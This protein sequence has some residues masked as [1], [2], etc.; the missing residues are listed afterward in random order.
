MKNI[1]NYIRNSPVHTD[2]RRA[3]WH[4]RHRKAKRANMFSIKIVQIA[5]VIKT[6]MRISNMCVNN[7]II[8]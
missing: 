2:F 1:R 3:N 7:H 6:D 5:A 8:D 4:T